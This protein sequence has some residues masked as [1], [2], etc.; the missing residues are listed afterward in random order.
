MYELQNSLLF[1]TL[2]K[3]KIPPASNT[4]STNPIKEAIQIKAIKAVSGNYC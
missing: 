1:I 2:L 4:S 3:I